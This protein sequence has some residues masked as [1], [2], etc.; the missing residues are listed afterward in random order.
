MQPWPATS[1]EYLVVRTLIVLLAAWTMGFA[2]EKEKADPYEAAR[3]VMAK[4]IE[5]QREA[6]R[7]QARVPEAADNGFVLNKEGFFLADWPKPRV[8]GS[9]AGAGRAEPM[10]RPVSG[11]PSARALGAGCGAIPSLRL[12]SYIEQAAK[13]E[14][15]APDLLRAVIH[16]E[17]AFD[18]C[19]VSSKGAQGLM[20]LMPETAADLGV[21]NPFDPLENINGGARYLGQLLGRYGGDLAL[22]LGAYNA[23]PTRVDRHQG[24]PPIPETLNYVSSILETLGG[25]SATDDRPSPAGI[26]LPELANPAA[27]DAFAR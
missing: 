1:D 10:A 17:S 7:R 27:W 2:G 5:R 23:G 4:A 6:A 16:Q 18:P 26:T 19:A 22:A 9:P 14:G 24:L 8:T 25:P 13:R 11:Q 21:R 20:Q 12:D 3:T 15:M